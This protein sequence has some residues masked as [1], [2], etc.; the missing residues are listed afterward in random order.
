[1]PQARRKGNNVALMGLSGVGK[2]RATVKLRQ[3]RGDKIK[4]YSVDEAIWTGKSALRDDFELWANEFN[5]N[6]GQVAANS[7]EVTAEYLGMLGDPSR[8]GLLEEE[9]RRR[10]ALHA[11]AERTA[12]LQI[13]NITKQPGDWVID[14]SGSF[15]EVVIRGTL[16]TKRYRRL[17]AA[18]GH[19]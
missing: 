17:V 11:E 14:L 4:S 10:Q 18:L 6:I 3:V 16:A 5:K 13:N 9:F 12:V 2:T 19:S 15:C 8:G 1:M 7:L